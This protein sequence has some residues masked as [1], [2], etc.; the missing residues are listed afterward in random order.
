MFDKSDDLE[1]PGKFLVSVLKEEGLTQKNLSE[2]TGL[3]EKHISQIINGEVSLSVET[4]LLLENVLPRTAYFWID[5]EK[6]YQEEKARLNRCDLIKKETGLLSKFPY[7]DLARRGLVSNTNNNEE[8]VSNLWKFFGVSSLLLIKNMEAVVYRKKQGILGKEELIS[9]WLR[10]GEI[11]FK[12]EKLPEYSRSGLKGV[13]TDLKFLSRSKP[14]NFLVQVKKCLNQVGVAIVYVPHFAGT[15]VSGAMRWIDNHPA[16]Q[17]SIY[18]RW[19]DIFWFNLFHE[20][21]HVLLHGKKEVFFEY[22]NNNQIVT[23]SQ[24]KE[25]D[26]FAAN[27]LISKKEYAKLIKKQLNQK[28]IKKFAQNL[29]IHPGIVVGR[30]CHDKKI[31]W[32]DFSDLRVKIEN[33]DLK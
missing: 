19:A 27:K 10:C 29:G 3:S 18:Y 26:L 16:I 25:V 4:A 33:K 28:E 1:Y 13:L 32:G 20:I 7:R 12:K 23:D 2:R 30:L 15:G 11:T 8:K 14:K 21:G 24:E 22:E 5:L 17:L 6:R 31:E 9:S